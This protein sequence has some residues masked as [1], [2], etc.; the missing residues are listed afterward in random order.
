MKQVQFYFPINTGARMHGELKVKA[1]IHGK[2]AVV[3]EIKYNN[4]NSPNWVDVTELL[5]IHA[6]SLIE[7]LECAAYNASLP[8]HP[9]YT[10]IMQEF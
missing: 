9:D 6:E 4:D 5:S 10:L 3:I 2:E 1:E 7:D 8:E